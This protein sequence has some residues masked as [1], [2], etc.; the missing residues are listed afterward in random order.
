[1]RI[2]GVDADPE[3]IA[4]PELDPDPD[5]TLPDTAPRSLYVGCASGAGAN[6]AGSS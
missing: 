2:R 5:E 1:M 3:L 6:P 4:D